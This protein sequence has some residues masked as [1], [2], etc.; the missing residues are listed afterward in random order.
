[1]GR[2]GP[3]LESYGQGGAG[4]QRKLQ[5]QQLIG[6]AKKLMPLAAESRGRPVWPVDK[7]VDWR[8][9]DV[10]AGVPDTLC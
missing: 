2:H 7:C 6:Q 3:Q 8:P 4:G 5:N 9:A 1:M 10:L